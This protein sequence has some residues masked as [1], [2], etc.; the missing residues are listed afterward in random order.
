MACLSP[1]HCCPR[2]RQLLALREPLPGMTRHHTSE[3]QSGFPS[4]LSGQLTLVNLPQ[5]MTNPSLEV[6]IIYSS[7]IPFSLS[8]KYYPCPMGSNT[9]PSGHSSTERSLP[10]NS[11]S[12]CLPYLKAWP[13]P[14]LPSTLYPSLLCL[15]MGCF[16]VPFGYGL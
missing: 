6:T 7:V 13:V 4:T 15:A 14:S 11:R 9:T 3:T 8:R 1:F 16:L 5:E 2:T 10:S 12:L